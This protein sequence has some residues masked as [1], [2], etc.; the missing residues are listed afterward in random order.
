MIKTFFIFIF[1][2]R[3]KG[4]LFVEHLRLKVYARTFILTITYFSVALCRHA[5]MGARTFILSIT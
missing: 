3:G 2:A 1:G 4:L 5:A